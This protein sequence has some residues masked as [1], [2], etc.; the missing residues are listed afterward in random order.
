MQ[1]NPESFFQRL[2]GMP[3]AAGLR[4][5]CGGRGA[6]GGCQIRIF[7]NPPL[8]TLADRRLIPPEKLRKGF[9]LA[10]MLPEDFQGDFEIPASCFQKKTVSLSFGRADFQGISFPL[11]K[12]ILAIDLGTTTIAMALYAKADGSV[13]ETW[14][15]LNPQRFYGADV[16]SRL[17]AAKEGHGERL[18]DLIREALLQGIRRI[19]EENPAKEPFEIFLAGNTSMLHLFCGYPVEKLSEAP[20]LPY[21]IAPDIISLGSYSIHTLPCFSAFVGA[22]IFADFYSLH[23]NGK[24]PFFLL[25]LG[26]NG[27]ML[28]GFPEGEGFRL[29]CSSAPAGP[30]F[31]GGASAGVYGADLVKAL[32][33]LRRSG[34]MD[35]TG[36]LA[37]SYF[38]EGIVFQAGKEEGKAAEPK[39][40]EEEGAVKR[41]EGEK[42]EAAE[43]KERTAEGG[44]K[45]W[46]RLSQQDIREL[47]K[48]K[49]AVAAG[50]DCLLALGGL[51]PE[52]CYLA[53]GFGYFL[54]PEDAAEI[55]L[56]PER[57]RH[58]SVSLGNAV[59][60]G[61][62]RYAACK[63]EG[64]EEILEAAKPV[65][66][67]TLP[68]FQEK[69]IGNLDFP[70]RCS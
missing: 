65:N 32:A 48:A 20:F 41:K 15:S 30:A 19:A 17:Q 1:N 50:I 59:L 60:P 13:L 34:K 39:K 18:R 46:F 68:D 9:R 11:E 23:W 69:Y 47:Q 38:K 7:A 49:G 64:A 51:A 4:V 27:E 61:I 6:C 53:G 35:A 43:F 26:T 70:D 2:L 52:K 36:L 3:E 54:Q 14:S 12:D 28:F 8:P 57:F 58:A 29:L 5:S 37:D 56:I 67:A 24:E 45:D 63:G 66:L 16:L 10:C 33:A 25:D 40:R 55:G 62:F 42:E 31:E 44:T 21:S 22:D